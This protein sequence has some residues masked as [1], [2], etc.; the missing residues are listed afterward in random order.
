MAIG[1]TPCTPGGTHIL[2]RLFCDTPLVDQLP[3]DRKVGKRWRYVGLKGGVEATMLRVAAAPSNPEA[4]SDMLDAM[5]S[6]LD[7]VDRNRAF[8]ERRIAWE[9]LP[10]NWLPMLFSDEIPSAEARLALA[11]VS[12]FPVDRPFA[13]YR[14]GISLDRSSRFIHPPEIPKQ[15]VW[16]SAAPISRVLSEV[17]YRRTLDWEKVHDEDEPVR[18]VMPAT[19]AQVGRWLSGFVDNELLARWIS[20]FALFDWRVAPSSVKL[21]A[22][23][24]DDLGATTGALCLFGLLQP[25]FDLR[26][27][28][29]A[30]EPASNLLPRE[31]GARTPAA[32]RRLLGLLRVRDITGAAGLAATRFAMAG[33]P[34]V[35]SDIPWNLVDAEGLMVSLLFPVSDDERS[36]LVKRWLRPRR[37]Q[38]G[39]TYD[40]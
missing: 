13:L 18:L 38:G 39:S 10:L 31:S 19:C 14:F 6:A 35:R 40:D 34:L 8:R 11:L 33:A 29:R 16:R 25:L 24:G 21:L 23:R 2:H 32:A 28:V 26:P 20:R 5:V 12:S 4:A 30:N 27:V 1:T 7:R 3:A 36:A 17:L 37:E 22:S 15:W 9:A